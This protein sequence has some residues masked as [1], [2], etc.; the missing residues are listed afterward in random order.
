MIGW[1]VVSVKAWYNPLY[2]PRTHPRV[3]NELFI[4]KL[5]VISNARKQKTKM[6]PG[7]EESG[8]GRLF[9]YDDPTPFFIVID[10][11]KKLT[12]LPFRT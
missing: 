1:R 5:L 3:R 2:R 7:H 11:I 8:T 10:R 4:C 9:T 12:G 6:P